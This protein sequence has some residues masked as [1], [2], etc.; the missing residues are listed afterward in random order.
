MSS[1]ISHGDNLGVHGHGGKKGNMVDDE[2]RSDEP[3]RMW[4][5][6]HEARFCM[7][8]IEHLPP[9]VTESWSGR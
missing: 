4:L 9:T 3:R 1:D 8:E 2:M 7:I 6:L 5:M